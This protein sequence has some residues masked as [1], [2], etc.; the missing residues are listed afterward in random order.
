[1]GGNKSVVAAWRLGG[2]L[3]H[4]AARGIIE[5]T[6][7]IEADTQFPHLSYSIYKLLFYLTG[8]GVFR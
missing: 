4:D 2:G 6:K 7:H 8:V 5:S 3:D 1:M